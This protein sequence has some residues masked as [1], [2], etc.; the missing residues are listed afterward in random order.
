MIRT[1]AACCLA[2]TAAAHAQ[3]TGLVPLNDLGTGT[4]AGFQGGLYP[5]GVNTPPAAHLAAALSKASEIVPRNAA[6]APDPNGFIAMIAVGMSNTTHEFG[7][8]E[9]AQ[10]ANAARNARVVL[11][12][13]GLGGQTATAIADPT[14]PYWTVM[15]QRISAMGLTAAQV[16]VA[17][18]KEAESHPA[19][20]FPVHAQGLRANLELI[21]N[22]LHD[23]F[24]NLKICYLS[25]RIYGGYSAAGTLNPEPQAYESGFS[26]KWLVE[27]QI[28]G[29]AGLNYGQLGGPVRAPLLMWGPYTWADGTN[30]R[31]DGLVWLLSDLESDRVHPSAAG[32]VKVAGLLASFFASD[33]TAA[34]WWPAQPGTTLVTVDAAAD[35]H[36]SAASPATNF[37]SSLLLLEQGGASPIHT[38]LRFDVPPTSGPI[39]RA[40][41]SLRVNQ[42]GG[43]RVSRVNDTTWSELGITYASAPSIG[44]LVMQLPQSSRDG[45]I[46]ADVTSSVISAGVGPLA[47][48]LTMPT[49][50]QADYHSREAGQPPRLVLVVSA[51]Q[52]PFLRPQRK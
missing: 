21:A 3:T 38:H 9:R 39:L 19:D 23:K 22:N 34:P 33:V 6:G 8:F 24:P 16:Q 4:H 43:G 48:A 46:A 30:P 50:S 5:G 18:L 41:L 10:D 28:N 35:A 44:S 49:A 31:S 25:S 13:T 52:G 36:V 11:I 32:E 42:A 51:P 2:L 45:T 37:G 27:D 17:W 14:A 47:F 40:K 26:V 15:Q 29:D 7:A 12:D 1:I 20:D